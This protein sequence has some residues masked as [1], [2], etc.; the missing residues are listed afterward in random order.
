VASE[1]ALE[2]RDME[3]SA[4]DHLL[5]QARRLKKE[6]RAF[7]RAA[8]GFLRSQPE[9]PEDNLD[10]LETDLLGTVE[11]LLNDDLG[12]AL[13]KLDE[14]DTLLKKASTLKWT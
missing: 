10:N 8:R 12:P 4:D 5:Q 9:K 1:P 14:L 11:C 7:G 3:Q 2:G 13:K 6:V